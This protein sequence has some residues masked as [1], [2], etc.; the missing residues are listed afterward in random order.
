M[1]F[2]VNFAKFI[3]TEH[4]SAA[5]HLLCTL[6]YENNEAKFGKNKSTFTWDPKRTQT[7]LKSQTALKCRFVY[8]AIYMEISQQ[9]LSKQ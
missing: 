1:Y 4:L 3:R 2:P 8:M 9:Q 7:G 6:F 5:V